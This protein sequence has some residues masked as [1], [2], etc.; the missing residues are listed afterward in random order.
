MIPVTYA[1][2]KQQLQANPRTWLVT[3]VAGFIGSNLLETL[4]TL[5][6]RVVGLDNFSTGYHHNLEAALTDVSV[7]T[8]RPRGELES[9]FHFV[10]G[11]IRDLDT[12]REAMWWHH[13]TSS[14][15][16][17]YVLHEAALCSEPRSIEDPIKTNQANIGGFL[18]ML[19]LTDIVKAQRL[20]GY[21]PSQRI[22]AGLRESMSWYVEHCCK[23]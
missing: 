23:A 1:A 13:G 5:G 19:A 9:Q 12:C 15:S 10:E 3:G 11:D 18:N 6:Q 22:D 4:L 21:A 14:Y 2:L 7:A 20:L 8:G 17:D 16:A